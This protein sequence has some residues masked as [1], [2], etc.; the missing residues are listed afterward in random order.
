M[1]DAV[2]L[3]DGKRI[4]TG[5]AKGVM[6]LVAVADGRELRA[7][8]TL[9]G[10]TESVVSLAI[11]R[12]G[13][14]LLSAEKHGLTL[15]DLQS[16]KLLRSIPLGQSADQ[17]SA[18]MTPDGKFAI[19]SL[20]GPE[21]A[22]SAGREAAAGAGRRP[23]RWRSRPTGRWSWPAAPSGPRYGRSRAGARSGR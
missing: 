23:R 15:W 4:L 1:T 20:E 8:R 6:R 5:D 10:H 2:F 18:L 16:N 3:P 11:T 21:R 13:T 19:A 14:R 9:S 17:Q 22:R 12:D 7:S